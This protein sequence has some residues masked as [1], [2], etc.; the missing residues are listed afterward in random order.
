LAGLGDLRFE[1]IV[2]QTTQLRGRILSERVESKL[3]E[4]G[5]RFD[6]W[7]P[8]E[9]F[10]GTDVR[11]GSAWQVWRT[12]G[13]RSSGRRQHS[14]VAVFYLSVY[15]RSWPKLDVGLILGSQLKFSIGLISG[16][17]VFGGFGGLEVRVDRV[18]DKTATWPY[19]F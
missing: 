12:C 3:A 8:V 7:Q 17:E 11:L 16:R 14:Y 1:K 19:L 5:R 10:N 2:S 9:V 13:L 15:N 18:L 6:F 4:I